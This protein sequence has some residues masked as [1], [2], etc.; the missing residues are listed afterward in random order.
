MT[1]R[2]RLVEPTRPLAGYI[3]GKKQLARRVIAAIEE[4]P[5]GI[6]AEAFVG[7]AGVFF[8]RSRAPKVEVINDLSRDVASFFRVLQ[9]HYPQLMDT[10]RWQVTSRA[11]FE[12]LVGLDPDRLTDLERAARFLYLQRL[13]FG[14]KVVGRVFGIDTAAPARFDVN[15]LG[16][17][18]EEAHERLAGVWIECLPWQEFLRRWDRPRTLFYLDPPYWGTEHYYGRGLF[19]RTDFTA[20]AAALKGLRGRFVMTV[21]DVPELRELFA[22]ARVEPLELSYTAGGRNAIRAQELL[23]RSP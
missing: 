2:Y 19:E 22:W 23:I 1:S 18:L 15:R 4:V 9:R 11:E 14:G 12:R 5:H 6:Y 8:R 16:P 3:G 13:S 10:L 7:M 21:N 17:L 20:L